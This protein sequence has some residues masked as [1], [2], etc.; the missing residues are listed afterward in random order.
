MAMY[1]TSKEL[2]EQEETEEREL[3]DEMYAATGVMQVHH[4]HRRMSAVPH[5]L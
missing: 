1:L 2:E 3:R 5:T 4:Y